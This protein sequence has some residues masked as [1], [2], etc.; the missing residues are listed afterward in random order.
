[1]RGS[2]AGRWSAGEYLLLAAGML[3]GLCSLVCL[4]AGLWNGLTLSL[5]CGLGAAAALALARS[6]RMTPRTAPMNPAPVMLGMHAPLGGG[7]REAAPAVGGA[8]VPVTVQADPTEAYRSGWAQAQALRAVLVDVGFAPLAVQ[9]RGELVL[10][11][12]ER[13]H[14]RTTASYRRRY[15]DGGLREQQAGVQVEATTRRLVTHPRSG[16]HVFDWECVTALRCN[17]ARWALELSFDRAQPL[18]LSGP[19][20]LT[21]AV[22]ATAVLHGLDGLREDRTLAVLAQ[23]PNLSTPG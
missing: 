6:A 14:L 16:V 4:A 10:A 5:I 9:E 20:A 3:S 13:V 15:G 8:V 23:T 2:S 21:L 12:T 18:V 17:V 11:A 7:A 22:Y 1:M 19:N